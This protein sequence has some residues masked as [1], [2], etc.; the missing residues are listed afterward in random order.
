MFNYWRGRLTFRIFGVFSLLMC[1]LYKS[2]MLTLDR[3]FQPVSQQGEH[4]ESLNTSKTVI[5]S[6]SFLQVLNLE[7]K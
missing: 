6:L 2:A 1:V 4:K 7:R 5:S 3:K